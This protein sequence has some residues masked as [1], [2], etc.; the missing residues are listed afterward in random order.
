MLKKTLAIALLSIGL[1]AHAEE[2]TTPSFLYKILS[3]EDWKLSQEDSVLHLSSADTDFI[4]FSRQDQLDRILTKYWAG[5]ECVVLKIDVSKLPGN[6]VFEANPGGAAKYYH[7][8]DGNI[9]L[10]AVVETK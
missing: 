8:Y 9:P 6:L 1:Q 2:E 10:T 5:L 4:H 3:T 7:L